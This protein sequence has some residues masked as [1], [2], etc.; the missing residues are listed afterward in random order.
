MLGMTRRLDFSPEA[1]LPYLFNALHIVFIFVL[2]WV[3]TRLARR[4]IRGLDAYSIRM[5]L[6]RNDVPDFEIRKRVQTISTVGART[7]SVLIWS[8]ALIMALYEMHF[9]VRPLIAGA[10]IIGVALGFGAQSL[11][12]DILSG[13]F[14]LVENQI[15][16]N[17]VAVINGQGGLVE[18][19]NLR[20]TVLRSEDGAVHIFP[21]GSIT[22]LANLTRDFSFA[23][24]NVKVDYREDS[25]RVIEEIRRIG[26]EVRAEEGFQQ[27]ILADLDML[28]VDS[29]ADSGYVIKFRFRTQPM[30]QW[31]VAREMNAR[32]RRRFNEAG[33]EMPFPAHLIEIG[34][35]T[36]AAVRAATAK[37]AP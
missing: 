20:T 10:G 33:I 24:F 21:N 7:L 36:L 28:G 27:V 11:I 3:A 2:A 26:A 6:R 34:P 9:D 8:M 22:T 32:I 17:D 23:V 31:M 16:I 1:L 18:E 35:E 37:P 30:K 4:V 13:F 19:I 12:R 29:L 5:M 15:R 25:D 14:L